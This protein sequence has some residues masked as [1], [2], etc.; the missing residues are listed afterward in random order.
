MKYKSKVNISKYFS[1]KSKDAQADVFIP[2]TLDD[3]L[4]FTDKEDDFYVLAG[5]TNIVAGKIKKPV[6]MM[7][8]FEGGN[9]HM[10]VS[11]KNYVICVNS[12]CF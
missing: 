5:G 10:K 1:I 9:Y 3:L 11:E 6:L 12:K 8:F 4:I 7:N 2:E